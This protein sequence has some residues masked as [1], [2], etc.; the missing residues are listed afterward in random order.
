MA[1]KG[2]QPGFQMGAE[3]RGKIKNSNILKR[4]INHAEGLEPNMTQSEVNAALSLL[5]RVMPKLKPVD[6][7]GDSTTKL[8]LTVR[9]GGD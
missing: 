3:H 5:D 4:L 6:E 7:S 8:E 9:I 1:S 2:R